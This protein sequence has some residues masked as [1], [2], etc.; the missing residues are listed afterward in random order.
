M[1]AE[2]RAAGEAAAATQ[3]RQ[4]D[5]AAKAARIPPELSPGEEGA[6]QVAVRLPSGARISHRCPAQ[7]GMGLCAG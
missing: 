2:E 3:R 6:V 7:S 1:Q 4:A 5:L